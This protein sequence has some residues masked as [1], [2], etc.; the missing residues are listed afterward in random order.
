MYILHHIGVGLGYRERLRTRRRLK[1]LPS[2]LGVLHRYRIL[3]ARIVEH[4]RYAVFRSRYGR[5]ANS[6][7]I[8]P[9][10]LN[11]HLKAAICPDAQRALR[12]GIGR[13]VLQLPV[14]GGRELQ[15]HEVS[16]GHRLGRED[17]LSFKFC[18]LRGGVVCDGLRPRAGLPRRRRPL[19]NPVRPY[20]AVGRPCPIRRE[21]LTRRKRKY[22]CREGRR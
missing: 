3:A 17:D 18:G 9:A 19:V 8:Q 4:D 14:E 21:S 10:G 11:P 1:R 12:I 2:A 7:N 15:R 20:R 13:I 22:N 16:G 5:N 6:G